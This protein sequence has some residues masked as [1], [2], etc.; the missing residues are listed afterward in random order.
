MTEENLIP[1]KK[2]ELQEGQKHSRLLLSSLLLD[3]R[4]VRVGTGV[5]L[6]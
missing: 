6:H 4:R 1:Q 2:K 3:A 5:T